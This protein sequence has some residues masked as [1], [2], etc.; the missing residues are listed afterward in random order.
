MA[1]IK[2]NRKE[3]LRPKIFL[4]LFRKQRNQEIDL[5]LLFN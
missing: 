5:E 4:L 2:A 1:A 3:Y